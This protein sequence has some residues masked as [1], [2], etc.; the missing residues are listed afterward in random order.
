VTAC[1]F[2]GAGEDSRRFL[3]QA[4]SSDARLCDH[5]LCEYAS[6][7]AFAQ[8]LEPPRGL[9]RLG[10]EPP[11]QWP[12]ERQLRRINWL[13]RTGQL[14][15]TKRLASVIAQRI[16]KYERKQE[17]SAS[18]LSVYFVQPPVR[19]LGQFERVCAFCGERR[20]RMVAG[21]A[22][23]RICVSCLEHASRTLLG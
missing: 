5:C 14:S 19:P 13:Q 10:V 9:A 21:K 15:I 16:A 8:G 3:V 22:G 17:A 23:G 11:K 1:S 20:P 4:R 18:P 12:L 2:C 6:K 7:A